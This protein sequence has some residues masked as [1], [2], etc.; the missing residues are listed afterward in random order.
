LNRISLAN[1]PSIL[2]QMSFEST[3]TVLK[4]SAIYGLSDTLKS[5]SAKLSV[6]QPVGLGTGVFGLMMPLFR[7]YTV[8]V[9]SEAPFSSMDNVYE[10]KEKIPV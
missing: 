3:M 9:D 4:K 7:P 8:S 6:G 10:V 1:A 5:P 2:L